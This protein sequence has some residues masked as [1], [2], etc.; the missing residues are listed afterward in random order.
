MTRKGSHELVVSAQ[1]TI[2]GQ[3]ARPQ[4]VSETE[5]PDGFK[6]EGR[7][8]MRSVHGEQA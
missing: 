7:I 3:V 2:H 1:M 8:T 4:E 5:Y 6:Q